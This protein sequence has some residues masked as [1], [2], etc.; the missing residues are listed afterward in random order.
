MS[1]EKVGMIDH[2]GLDEDEAT[3]QQDLMDMITNK[4]CRDRTRAIQTEI[5]FDI[6][7]ACGLVRD[8]NFTAMLR[9]EIIFLNQL[10]A[11]W[12]DAAPEPTPVVVALCES[13]VELKRE[14]AGLPQEEDIEEEIEDGQETTQ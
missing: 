8:V 11:A 1:E 2:V 9:G 6:G 10:I 13:Y 12:M 14:E 3:A 5:G 4:L 7:V